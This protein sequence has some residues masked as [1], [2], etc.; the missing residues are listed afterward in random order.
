MKQNKDFDLSELLNTLDRDVYLAGVDEVGRGALF[1]PV[2]AASVIVPLS[3]LEQLKSMGVKDSKKLSAKRRR[4]LSQKIKASGFGCQIGYASV[5]KID[6]VNIFHATLEA[7]RRSIILLK[8]KPTICLI[9]GTH[10]IPNLDIKQYNLIKGDERSPLIAAASIIAKVWRDDLIER[11]AN[12]YPQYD[13]AS[14]K[15]YGTKKHLEAL[16]ENGISPQ[17]RLSFAPCRQA[18]GF[19]VK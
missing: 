13:L 2:V 12:K 3:A 4:E 15:G 19:A 18:K 9:D 8:R 14:N 7:M 5:K 16:R 6:T 10:P 1:G 11:W 17:H